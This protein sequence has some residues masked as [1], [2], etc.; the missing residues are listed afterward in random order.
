MR[1]REIILNI[2]LVLSVFLFVWFDDYM[3]AT[4]NESLWNPNIIDFD[5]T[6]ISI[7]ILTGLYLLLQKL[8]IS[9]RNAALKDKMSE[10]NQFAEFGRLASG[11]FHDIMNP[12]TALSLNIGSLREC[13][14]ENRESIKTA[15]E[16]TRRMESY[17]K[18]ISRHIRHQEIRAEFSLNDEIDNALRLLNHKIITSKTEILTDCPN[19]ILM[20]GDPFKFTRILCNIISNAIDALEARTDNRMIKIGL[21]FET[22]DKVFL[23]VA[24]NGSGMKKDILKKIFTPFF[25]TKDIHGTGIGLSSSKEMIERDFDGEI[26][27]DSMEGHGTGS[28]DYF[29]IA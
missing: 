22:D 9:R 29:A 23:S 16:S 10:S 11:I 5:P 4:G 2:L 12:F 8:R 27:I 17:F 28:P 15:V 18:A 24:D 20:L 13:C 14:A 1:K 19:E 21:G 26:S 3:S 6:D 25:T 7:L